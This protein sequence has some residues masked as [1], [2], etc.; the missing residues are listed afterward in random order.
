MLFI[1]FTI[2]FATLYLLAITAFAQGTFTITGKLDSLTGTRKVLVKKQDNASSRVLTVATGQATNGQFTLSQAV[3]EMDYYTVSIEGVGGQVSF[4]LDHDVVISGTG[5][6]LRT[7]TVSGSPL[8]DEWQRF[9]TGIELPY[10]D[11]LMT[12]YNERQQNTGNAEVAT[13]VETETKRLKTEQMAN[14]TAYIRTH[15]DSPLSLFLL[16]NYANEFPKPESRALFYGLAA[17]LR[18]HS[19]AKRLANQ[20]K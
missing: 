3:P 15:A 20:V 18:N 11:K 7:A 12:L 4:I 13:R 17:P 10:R 14:V 19:V 6:D 1:R 5:K 8:T 16:S 2:T 9:Q